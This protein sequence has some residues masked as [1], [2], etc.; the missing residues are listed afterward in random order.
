M[1]ETEFIAGDPGKPLCCHCYPGVGNNNVLCTP[2]FEQLHRELNHVPA[3]AP[4]HHVVRT[5]GDI[6]IPRRHHAAH[7][8]ELVTPLKTVDPLTTSVL[9]HGA[10]DIGKSFQAACLVRRG[11]EYAATGGGLPTPEDFVWTSTLGLIEQIIGEFGKRPK[12]S[13]VQRVIDARVLVLDDIGTT[14]MIDDAKSDWAYGKLLE[15]VN[16]RYDALRPII[17]TSN[18]APGSELG[19]R[20]GERIL[21]RLLDEAVVVELRGEPRRRPSHVSRVTATPQQLEVTA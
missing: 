10:S 4:L 17:A 21:G 7:P 1:T 12:V 6:V 19:Q 14:R 5:M 20:I 16:Q 9:L 18:L 3:A 15:V 8:D 13:A 11:V 2:H